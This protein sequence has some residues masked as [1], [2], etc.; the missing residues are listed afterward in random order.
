MLVGGTNYYIQ[1]VIWDILI[2]GAKEKAPGNAED[3]EAS[4]NKRARLEE[5]SAIHSKIAKLIQECHQAG[6]HELKDLNKT[7]ETSDMSN[8]ELYEQLKQ[9]DA[10]MAVKLH[11]NDRRKICRSL[12]V[13][14][15]HGVTKTEL[16][17]SKTTG[18]HNSSAADDNDWFGELRYKN[19][20]I[21][22]MNCETESKSLGF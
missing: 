19:A 14:L 2:E 13:Y 5:D 11:P 3:S 8:Q 10:Q 16:L 22:V 4:K 17:R 18:E 12:Q 21:F 15:S 20:C 6:N 7:L 1:S 9:V